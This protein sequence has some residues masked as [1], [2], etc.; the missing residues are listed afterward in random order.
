MIL[1]T[2]SFDKDI[3][4]LVNDLLNEAF[5]YYDSFDRKWKNEG[6]SFSFHNSSHI[7]AVIKTAQML[8]IAAIKGDDPL[9]LLN[10]L[11]KWNNAYKN[12]N[13]S[14]EELEIILR[15]AFAFHDLGNIGDINTAGNFVFLNIYKA[16]EAEE[17]SKKIATKLIRN[18]NLPEDLKKRYLPLIIEIIEQT[19]LNYSDDEG[20]D[21]PFAKFVRICDQIGSVLFRD[22][23]EESIIGLNEEMKKEIGK[24]LF[25]IEESRYFGR[26]RFLQLIPDVKIR[27]RILKI[28]NRKFR[29]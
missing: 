19:K 26:K 5:S 13:I 4:S 29:D 15:L 18:S 24:P 8:Y 6:N 1:K 17:R 28:L 10:D 22:D 20:S 2:N 14:K 12:T 7:R 16:E 11:E 23:F 27:K 21:K 25:S 9:N 3:D